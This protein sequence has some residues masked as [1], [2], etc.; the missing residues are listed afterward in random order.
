MT[1]ISYTVK[2][3][4][5]KHKK[6]LIEQTDYTIRDQRIRIASIRIKRQSILKEGRTYSSTFEEITKPIKNK[7]NHSSTDII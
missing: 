3:T 2:L 4:L 6:L 7:L 5:I 1:R